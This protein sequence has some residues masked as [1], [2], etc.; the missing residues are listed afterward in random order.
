M[1]VEKVESVEE[2]EYRVDREDSKKRE[3]STGVE[4]RKDE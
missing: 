3:R 4:Y 2:M 1:R